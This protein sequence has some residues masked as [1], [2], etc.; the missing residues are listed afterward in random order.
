MRTVVI[1][2]STDGSYDCL[3]DGWR[4]LHEDSADSPYIP[5]DEVD[6]VLLVGD[7][8]DVDPNLYGEVPMEQCGTIDRLQDL[9]AYRFMD[10]AFL[11][12]GCTVLGI[13]KGAQQLCVRNDGTLDQH[14][15]RVGTHRIKTSLGCTELVEADHHQ[16]MRPDPY[17][18]IEAV[19]SDEG[20]PELVWSDDPVFG[21][22]AAFQWHPEWCDPASS[23]F[24][25]FI[26]WRDRLC[27]EK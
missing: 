18:T 25:M 27:P 17:Y 12:A 8:S 16:V 15:D 14:V 24:Q 20:Y 9:E 7:S 3:F 21:V 19:N 2:S 6:C 10:R 4:I 23:G 13:C 11:E 5:W 26:T 1:N 22:W